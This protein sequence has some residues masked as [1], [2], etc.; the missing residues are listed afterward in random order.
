MYQAPRKFIHFLLLQKLQ[1]YFRQFRLYIFYTKFHAMTV[2]KEFKVGGQ[3]ILS[4]IVVLCNLIS[5]IH[6]KEHARNLN[7]NNFP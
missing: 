2:T 3:N 1:K 6:R 5:L 4:I 7:W